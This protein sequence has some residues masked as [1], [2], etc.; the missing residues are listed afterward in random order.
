MSNLTSSNEQ[1]HST[2]NTIVFFDGICHF[3]NDIVTM[4][5]T[6]DKHQILR[7]APLQGETYAALRERIP[8]LPSSIDTI[9]VYHDG[10]IWMKSSAVFKIAHLLGGAWKLALIGQIIQRFFRDA[11]YDI[12]ARHRYLWFGK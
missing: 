2:P 10:N 11:T 3:C 7:Y 1:Y 4:L 8:S 9:I 5:M 12:I 6:H